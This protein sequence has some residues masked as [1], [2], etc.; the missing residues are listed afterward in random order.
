M[1]YFAV[2]ETSAENLTVMVNEMIAAGWKP[3][4]GM[5]VAGDGRG[6]HRFFCQA[7]IKD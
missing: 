6:S 2:K 4:G 3:L 7:M 1:E 5:S